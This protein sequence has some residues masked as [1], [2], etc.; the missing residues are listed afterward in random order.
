M[1]RSDFSAWCAGRLIVLDGATGTELHKAGLPTGACPDAW[2]LEHPEALQAIQRRYFDVGSDVVSSFTFGANPRKLME[3]GFRESDAP[4]VNERLVRISRAICPAGKL[5][6]GGMSSSGTFV[7]PFGELHFDEAVRLFALQVKGL[8]A[9]GADLLVIETMLDIQETRAALIAARETCDL[10][11]LVTMTFDENGRTLT[12]TPP[13]AAAVTLQSLGASA[14]GCNCSAGPEQMGRFIARMR[15]VASVPLVAKPNAG[16][17]VMRDGATVF[18]MQAEEF[19][20]KAAAIAESGACILGGCCGT[21]PEHIAALRTQLAGKTAP[22]AGENAMLHL[23]SARRAVTVKS[24]G[25]TLVVGERINPTGKKAL[26]AALREKNWSEVRRLAFEQA[27]DGADLLDVNAGMP[28]IDEKATMLELVDLLSV[29]VDMPLC[30]DSSSPEVLETALRQYQGRALVNSVSLERVKI[31]TLLPTVAKYGAAF[32]A[33]PVTDDEVPVTADRRAEIVRSI[34]AAAEQ[35][36]YRRHELVVDGLVMAVSSDAAAARQTLDTVRW[37]SAEFGANTILG[38]SNASF[39]LPE[40]KWINAAFLSMAIQAGVRFV[41]ANPGEETLRA[42][43]L[44]ADVLCRRDANCLAYIGHFSKVKPASALQS[45]TSVTLEPAERAAHAVLN[46][47][48]PGAESAVRDA[49]AAKV[50][51]A[52]LVNAHLI[53]A[54]MQAG[55][56]FGA[57]TYFLPQLMLSAEAMDAAFAILSPLLEAGGCEPAGTAVLATVKGDIHDIGKNIVALMLRNHGFRVIDLGKDVPAERIVETAQRENADVIGLSALMTTT[58][59]GMA[60]VIQRVRTEGVRARVMVGGA[61]VTQAYADEIR[62]DGYAADA[63]GAA[64]MA[65]KLTRE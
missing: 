23:S 10:P 11:V 40:R 27:A 32:V 4:S 61:V 28:G 22:E 53:P 34:W 9:G 1:K 39:G 50:P 35:F 16:L 15:A 45:A 14:V 63:V 21:T 2:V 8:V 26:Q 3:Y 29:A 56:R 60:D 42:A 46:G 43:R 59:T 30:L 49:I 47:D 54:I 13:E 12:G 58:M 65:L 19:G 25:P 52:E 31:E 5:V 7:R 44:S 6:A 36:G 57:G 24:D 20:R 41:I 51:A 33:L 64:R 62:A 55:D 17:P 48:R 37:A 18:T 38:L